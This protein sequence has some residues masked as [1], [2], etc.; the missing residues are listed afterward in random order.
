[1]WREWPVRTGSWYQHV[2][3]AWGVKQPA[4]LKPAVHWYL[5][6]TLG[7]SSMEIW[8][9]YGLDLVVPRLLR[10]AADRSQSAAGRCAPAKRPRNCCEM[11]PALEQ[12]L[13]TQPFR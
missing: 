12:M 10:D 3:T 2:P 5:W 9:R 7:F 1:M 8:F 11:I 4:E 6:Q 13:R